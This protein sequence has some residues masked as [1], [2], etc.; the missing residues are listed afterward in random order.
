V[1]FH[2]SI[3]IAHAPFYGWIKDAFRKRSDPDLFNS[4]SADFPT[5]PAIISAVFRPIP[6]SSG[7]W[8][9]RQGITMWAP[10]MQAQ[11]GAASIDAKM[12]SRLDG[13][14]IFTFMTGVVLGR[15][16]HLRRG[17]TRCRCSRIA[18]S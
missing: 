9:D 4:C 3:E 17:N 5:T 15:P 2:V 12:I 16:R 10:T 13:P 7:F 8:S 11:S 14:L 18:S 1:L 6:A